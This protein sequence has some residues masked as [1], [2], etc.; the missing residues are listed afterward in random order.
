[1]GWQFLRTP[2]DDVPSRSRQASCGR[3]ARDDR[4]RTERS[5][6]TDRLAKRGTGTIH[7]TARSN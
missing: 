2:I 4:S 5:L 3:I 7:R 6:Q 1:M